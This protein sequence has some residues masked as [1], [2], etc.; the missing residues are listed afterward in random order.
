VVV[1]TADFKLEGDFAG[2]ATDL[3]R[4]TE[5][6]R[7]GVLLL[8]SDSTNADRPGTTPPESSVAAGLDACLRG[9]TGRVFVTTFASHIERIRAVAT[10]A[11]RHGR[12]V[13]LVGTS[14]LAHT[15]VAEQLGYLGIPASLRVAP[16]QVMDLPAERVLVLASGSQ[17][18]PL[19][20]MARLS[21]GRHRQVALEAG[22]L[23][24]HSA[25]R[26][27]GSEKSIG[28]MVNQFMR[29]GAEVITAGEAPIHVSGHASAAELTLLLSR[30]R[31][32]FFVPIHGEYRQLASHARLAREA[33]MGA[34]DVLLAESGD[35]IEVDERRLARGDRVH[36]GQVFIDDTSE[37][38]DQ[39]VLHDRRHIAGDGI[40]VAV[41]AVHR[42]SGLVGGF[43]E[44]IARGF[45]PIPEEGDGT[46]IAQA[47]SR[48]AES[49][50][51]AAPEERA[52][53]K[54]LRARIQ[55]DLK[56]FLR[57]HTQRQ[58]L[59]IPIIVEL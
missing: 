6:G 22:D 2:S 44:I 13:A 11:G 49:V 40:V 23:V 35:V 31:P 27:P 24:L 55:A 51:S 57:R 43:P 54:Q 29:H 5:L 9:R 18:E 53:E 47:R 58:P 28:R 56:R 14:L 25:R 38:V 39:A 8:L 32:R 30:L 17:G 12:R 41:V 52:D 15:D 36:A 1:H 19:S 50:A 7:Q 4:L 3:D 33:G 10:A 45:A 46:L 16:E 21:L 48:V 59:I 42:E 26:I 20:A 37:E 34:Q